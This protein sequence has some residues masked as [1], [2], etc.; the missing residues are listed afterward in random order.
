MKEGIF[1]GSSNSG[2][3]NEAL[4][5]AIKNAKQGLNSNYVEWHINEIEGEHGGVDSLNVLMIKILAYRGP[6]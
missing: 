3:F 6:K 5:A 2:S 1:S 4:S